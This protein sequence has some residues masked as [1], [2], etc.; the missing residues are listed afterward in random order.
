MGERERE[1]TEREEERERREIGRNEKEKENEDRKRQFWW[2]DVE[3]NAHQCGDQVY[4]IMSKRE[5][6]SYF[7]PSIASTMKLPRTSDS[8]ASI[9]RIS[10][11]ASRCH[12]S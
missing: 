1:E 8:T 11:V 6:S 5:P 4:R 9:P 2:R 3:L 10:K 7:V 12:S